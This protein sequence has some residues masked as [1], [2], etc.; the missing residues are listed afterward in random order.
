MKKE[1][2][3]EFNQQ[4]DNS[5]SQKVDVENEKETIKIEVN[6][7]SLII[8]EK[9]N[10]NLMENIKLKLREINILNLRVTN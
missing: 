9:D 8:S 10:V 2:I 1:E 7:E 4:I 5:K 3:K 6:R